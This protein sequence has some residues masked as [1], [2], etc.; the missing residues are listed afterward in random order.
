M[1]LKFKALLAASALSLLFEVLAWTLTLQT[2]RTASDG[3]LYRA[4]AVFHGP[5]EAIRQYAFHNI[6][7]HP[8]QLEELVM[9]SVFFGVALVQWFL[10][11]SLTSLL[12][13]LVVKLNFKR[14][15]GH[16]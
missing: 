10:L 4:C 14:R 6:E 8:T 15:P 7:N 13:P 2:A 11:F 5:A 3:M 12:V 1:P 9:M 16:S